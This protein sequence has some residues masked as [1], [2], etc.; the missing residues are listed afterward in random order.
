MHVAVIHLKT[1]IYSGIYLKPDNLILTWGRL[2]TV[3]KRKI[4]PFLFTGIN[5]SQG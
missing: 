4:Q 5:H 1:L 3:E 2:T